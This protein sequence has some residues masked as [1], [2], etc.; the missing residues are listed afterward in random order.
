MKNKDKKTA[1]E[2]KK[3]VANYYGLNVYDLDKKSRKR[4]I[5]EPRQI[6][7]KIIKDKTIK[8][9]LREVGA[10]VG[11]KKH[12]CVLHSI[13][14]VNNMIDTD[15]EYKERYNYINEKCNRYVSKVNK[16]QK[17]IKIDNLLLYSFE[18]NGVI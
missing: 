7:H 9:S 18:E 6:A 16:I 15:K 5:I 4:E 2:I 12:D 17:C 11:G 14:T 1:K 3:I 8:M 10:E 13:K